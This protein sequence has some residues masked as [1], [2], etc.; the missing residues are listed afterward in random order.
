MN[1][2][3]AVFTVSNGPFDG[4]Q[5][6][7]N[8][9]THKVDDFG[10]AYTLWDT[11]ARTRLFLNLFSPMSGWR[12]EVNQAPM[13][14]SMEDFSLEGGGA[15][16]AWLFEAR[17][18]NQQGDVVASASVCQL[19]NCPMAVE[20]GQTRAR[21]KLYQALG[22]PGTLGPDFDTAET[23]SK[24]AIP[25]VEF[26]PVTA[27]TSQPETVADDEPSLPPV[28]I[29]DEAEEA[30]VGS[31]APEQVVEEATAASEAEPVA[32]AP[33]RVD[34]LAKP[35][36]HNNALKAI[37]R[38]IEVRAKAKGIEVP[39]FSTVQ[40]ASAFLAQLAKPSSASSA[41]ADMLQGGAA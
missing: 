25:K 40:E 6:S 1:A 10:N 20:V 2:S 39:E 5:A 12:V 38:Q 26:Q 13:G 35:S 31:E 15:S 28:S 9:L 27:D 11:H 30:V 36:V 17:L 29:Q 32:A 4:V 21:G 18:I 23:R 7:E 41:Q 24:Q 19:I 34:P 33:S 8:D 3:N 16:P 22:L 14:L 37:V